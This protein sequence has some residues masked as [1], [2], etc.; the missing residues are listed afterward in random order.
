MRN[1]VLQRRSRLTTD[2]K[3]FKDVYNH[4]F[5]LPLEERK[6]AIELEQA[7]EFW[8]VL[9]SPTG[10]QWQTK[11]TPWLSWWLEF[12]NAKWKRAVNKDLWK[13]TLTFAEQTLKDESLGF[14]NEES[15]WP[16]V[17]D[18]FVEWVKTEKRPSGGEDAMEVE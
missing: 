8:K 14:W 18:E 7:E 6:K 17:I 15:S 5:V 1:L 16:S 12:L 13:Q 9:F 10:L 2:R 11:N 4:T 3:L